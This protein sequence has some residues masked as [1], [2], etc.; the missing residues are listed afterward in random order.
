MRHVRFRI[1]ACNTTVSMHAGRDLPRGT[2][3]GIE[4][5]LEPALGEGWLKRIM[6]GE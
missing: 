2:L 4:K 3:R 6:R 5:D 1:G